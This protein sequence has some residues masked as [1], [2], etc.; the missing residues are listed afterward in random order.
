MAAIFIV[1][2]YIQI[3]RASRQVLFGESLV[4]PSF[5]QWKRMFGKEHGTEGQRRIMEERRG[6]CEGQNR[7]RREEEVRRRRG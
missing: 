5:L 1:Q 6:G 2:I 3:G 7:K 4:F